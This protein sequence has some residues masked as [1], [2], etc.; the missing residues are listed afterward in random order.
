MKKT[1]II[2]SMLFPALAVAFPID[3]EKHLNGAEIDIQTLDLGNNM[4]SASLSNYGQR[5]AVCTVRFRNGP[6]A[7][8]TRKARV[9]A[10]ETA[11]LT[12]KFN[13]SV[14]RMRVRVECKLD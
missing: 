10:G 5:A 9:A 6:E 3:V 8:R 11:H 13:N 12:A 7:P 1:I 4:A 2:L 14:I